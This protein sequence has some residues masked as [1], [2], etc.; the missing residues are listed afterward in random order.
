MQTTQRKTLRRRAAEILQPERPTDR[1]STYVDWF[2]IVL[3]TLN[4]ADVVL[5]SVPQF[6]NAYRTQMHWFELFS[7][8]VFTVEYM[9]RM[10]CCVDV[11]ANEKRPHWRVRLAYFISPMALIDLVAILPFYLSFFIAID[12]R[13]LRVIRILRVF[14]LT[15][16]SM[17]MQL[18]LSVFREEMSSFVA[19]FSMLLTLL[20]MAA[21]G[22][23]LIE[24][25]IQPE[26]FGSIPQ[27]MWWAM[28]TLTTVGYGD[29]TPITAGGKF[30]GGAITV[31][32]MG[33]VA[34]PAGILASGFNIQMQ[35][36]Q[37]KFNIL[38]K[39]ILRDGIV[40]DTEWNDLE[41]LRKEL[42][43]DKE[44]S[45]LLIQL[46]EN[47]KQ[48]SVDCPHCGNTVHPLRRGDD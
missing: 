5:E 39:D 37:Q 17:A 19:A 23:Y 1:W 27:A 2:L 43:L 7:I 41:L 3:I 44:E 42:D 30:F 34:L 29:V 32:S 16:Y 9:L 48:A 33:M 11:A 13:F 47:K 38:L 36:R 12:L 25:D 6:R 35:R 22:I 46:A 31:I 28:A 26:H 8:A 4:V 40:T 20:V 24:H 10:W 14:K 45:E 21:S 18:I 15:R